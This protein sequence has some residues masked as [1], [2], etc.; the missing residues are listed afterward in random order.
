MRASRERPAASSA[1]ISVRCA[2]SASSS[3]EDRLATPVTE[4]IVVGMEAEAGRED[5]VVRG[6][7]PGSGLP[8]GR[9]TGRRGVRGQAQAPDAGVQS[10]RRFRSRG[11]RP[12]GGGRGPVLVNLSARR[13][14]SDAGGS[15]GGGGCL[16]R[17][18]VVAALRRAVAVSARAARVAAIVASMSDGGDPVVG[19]RAHLPVR[20]FDHDDTACSRAARKVRRSR[21][22]RNRTKFVRTLAGSSGPGFDSSGRS[23]PPAATPVHVRERLSEAASVGVVFGEPLDHPVGAVG[24]G[25]EP[26]RGEDA[27]LSH[28]AADHLSRPT[29]SPDDVPPTDHDRADGARQPLRQAEGDGVGRIRQVGRADVRAQRPRSRSGRRRCGAGRRGRRD[30]GHLAG[31]G[32]RQRLAHRMGV[33]VLDGDEAGDRLVGVVRVAE[34]GFDRAGSIVP[35]GRSSSARMLAPTMTA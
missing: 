8:R 1:S 23:R 19:D 21:W 31:I 27:G 14:E 4:E 11:E 22:T 12:L 24:E 16:D 7:G 33:R 35:S 25:H 13:A 26:G 34:G 17:S 32:R 20:V 9:R 2:L 28:P 29:R 15:R 3:R 6:P 18:R 30:L 10:G 5:R